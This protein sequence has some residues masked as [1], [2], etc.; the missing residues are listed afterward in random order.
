MKNKF[1][2]YKDKLN[3]DFS[4]DPEISFGHIGLK[5]QD[6][7]DKGEFLVFTYSYL[8]RNEKDIDKIKNNE[9]IA[10]D[11]DIEMSNLI[12]MLTCF[13]TMSEQTHTIPYNFS[14]TQKPLM[15]MK[16]YLDVL[17]KEGVE[18]IEDIEDE[19]ELENI[20]VRMCLCVAYPSLL[21][22]PTEVA[23]DMGVD[24]L[25]NYDMEEIDIFKVQNLYNECVNKKAKEK[26]TLLENT[27]YFYLD[28]LGSLL[29]MP[30]R[31]KGRVYENYT[32]GEPKYIYETDT[33][34]FDYLDEY[35]KNPILLREMNVV[36]KDVSKL[37]ETITKK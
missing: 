36:V 17:R 18:D 16:E 1:E 4:T 27:Y 29:D 35:D 21:P 11:M 33:A 14:I 31:S 2:I 22:I 10:L 20:Y 3:I 19:N 24:F 9:N 23:L 37:V 5:N 13:H 30:F 34:L 25:E 28:N 26:S 8:I 6:G 32:I 15:T 7:E 12:K